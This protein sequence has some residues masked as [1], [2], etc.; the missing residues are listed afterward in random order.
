MITKLLYLG[1]TLRDRDIKRKITD[2]LGSIDIRSILFSKGVIFVEG[3]SDKGVVEKMMLH[4]STKGLCVNIEENGWSISEIDGKNNL[5]R[6]IRIANMLRIPFVAILDYD[7][8][9][10]AEIGASLQTTSCRSK[11]T[12]SRIIH[13]LNSIDMLTEEDK[14]KIINEQSK[15]S[16]ENLGGKNNFWYMQESFGILNEIVR[17]KNIFVFRKDLEGT[18]QHPQTRQKPLK[19]LERITELILG[20]DVPVEFCEMAEFVKSCIESRN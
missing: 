3:P 12:T 18:L 19:N 4:M 6:F 11:I 1:D 13:A 9:M 7:A 16:V 14:S 20:D 10:N 15:T 8:L 17:S 2:S 5:E